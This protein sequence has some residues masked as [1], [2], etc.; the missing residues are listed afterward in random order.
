MNNKEKFEVK[1]IMK[2][3]NIKR[4]AAVVAGAA[5]VASVVSPALAAVSVGS[6]A[7][8]LVASIK[9][10]PADTTVVVGASAAI[11]DGVSAAKI[12]AVLASMNYQ[13]TT[14]T[15]TPVYSGSKSVTVT[16]GATTA[17]TP[18]ASVSYDELVNASALGTAYTATN[19]APATIT[20]VNLGNVLSQ[21]SITATPNTT[22]TSTTY[23]YEDQ[24][25]PASTLAAKYSED[26]SGATGHGLYLNVPNAALKYQIV[27]S[28]PLPIGTS[29]NYQNTPQMTILG[30]SYGIDWANTQAG[31]LA[32]FSGDKQTL[33]VGDQITSGTYQVSFTNEYVQSNVDMAI[34]TVKAADGT[35]QTTSGLASGQS[36]SMTF[37]SDTV[38]I[39]IDSVGHSAGT[40]GTGF[41]V[42]RV[43]TGTQKLSGGQVF[44]GNT[45]WVIDSVNTQGSGATLAL[46]SIVMRYTNT[47]QGSYSNGL[48]AGSVIN[49]PITASGN[50]LFTVSL[51]GFGSQT[52]TAYYT[53]PVA[54]SATGQDADNSST[55]QVQWADRDG[56]QENFAPTT[57][58]AENITVGNVSAAWGTGLI[59]NT[60]SGT[61]LGGLN[62][63]N[64]QSADAKWTI[65]NDKVVYLDSV[66]RNSNNQYTVNFIVGGQNGQTRAVAGLS[67]AT[68]STFAYTSVSNPIS[69]NF[70][71]DDQLAGSASRALVVLQNSSTC[72]LGAGSVQFGNALQF[73]TAPTMDLSNSTAMFGGALRNA[74]AFVK[75]NGETTA[76]TYHGTVGTSIQLGLMAGNANAESAG[77]ISQ[78]N[79]STVGYN[80]NQYEIT[81]RSTQLDGSMVGKVTLT[82]PSAAQDSLIAFSGVASNA[83]TTAAGQQVAS[84]GQTVGG[85]TINS[86]T[87]PTATTT[88]SGQYYTAIKAGFVPDQMIQVDQVAG[89]Y[90]IVV[91]GPFVNQVAQQ[92]TAASQ[93]SQEGDQIIA[94]EGSKLLVAGYS[95][96]DTDAAAAQLI[97]LLKA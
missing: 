30:K 2:S 58:N 12:A 38:T 77:Y 40:A 79:P 17:S 83:T 16:P 71:V 11:S 87:C 42:V 50:P 28:T 10:A 20:R 82:I 89:T 65:I 57:Q 18:T 1:K 69:C 23:Y 68:N 62:T 46:T 47:Y 3:L 51:Q 70:Q 5:M 48:A 15:G 56:E 34:F 67:N 37:G 92:M 41:A 27:F 26:P 74:T 14:V 93:I 53:T 81:A 43:G 72:M 31:T 13:L 78:T 61:I 32:L 35:T 95:A 66:Q 88:V 63:V 55:I 8:A 54:I 21:Q 4:V 59:T 45:N 6:G 19:A 36:Y 94:A 80:S 84:E 39:S 9:A 91:G 73:T 85:V 64:G 96:T 7:D 90:Q 25:V 24:I 75:A 52:T 49:G 97:A 22:G 76:V 60:T 33:N 29:V 86:I 44:P